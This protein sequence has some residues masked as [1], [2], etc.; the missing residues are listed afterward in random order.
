MILPSIFARMDSCRLR[1]WIIIVYVLFE[2]DSHFYYY[3][4]K[5]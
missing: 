1:T 2:N 5:T 3:A 4:F